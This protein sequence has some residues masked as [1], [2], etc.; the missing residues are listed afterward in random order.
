MNQILI[1][2]HIQIM[3]FCHLEGHG[4]SKTSW[5]IASKGKT[6]RGRKENTEGRKP[7]ERAEIMDNNT[8][9][10]GKRAE[11]QP[12]GLPVRKTLRMVDSIKM[13]PGSISSMCRLQYP[14]FP[15]AS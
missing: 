14:A 12:L 4:Q 5:K 11:K 8:G 15:A 3:L 2:K 1:Y 9:K 13:L 6:D 7:K 10:S